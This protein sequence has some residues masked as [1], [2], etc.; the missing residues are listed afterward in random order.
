MRSRIRPYLQM[1]LFFL[2]GVTLLRRVIRVSSLGSLNLS[3]RKVPVDHD[4]FEVFDE[5]QQ[6][7]RSSVEVKIGETTFREW[8]N[9]TPSSGEEIVYGTVASDDEPWV[10][11]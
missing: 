9:D 6:W 3:G 5:M 11:P 4:A 8:M 10:S 1:K 2:Q 7:D